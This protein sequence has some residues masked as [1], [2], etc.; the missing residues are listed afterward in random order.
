MTGLPPLQELGTDLIGT[1]SRRRRLILA[2]PFAYLTLY[3]LAAVLA[4][5]V[6]E[7]VFAFFCGKSW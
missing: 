5:A 1:S 6:F 2:R 3:L 7:S 4:L